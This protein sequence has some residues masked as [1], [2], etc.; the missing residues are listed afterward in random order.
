M[1]ATDEPEKASTKIPFLN[2]E[3]FCESKIVKSCLL[4]VSCSSNDSDV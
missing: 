2:L 3:I 1:S 4:T